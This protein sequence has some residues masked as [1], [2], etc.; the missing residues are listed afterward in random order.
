MLE[1]LAGCPKLQT[2]NLSGTAIGDAAIPRLVRLA[3]LRQINL[4]DTRISE[5][6]VRKLKTQ[7]PEWNLGQRK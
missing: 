1:D 4:A 7:R 2:L 6:G 3:T 5:T